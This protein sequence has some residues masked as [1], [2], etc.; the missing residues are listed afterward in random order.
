MDGNL[1]VQALLQEGIEALRRAALSASGITDHDGAPLDA[2]VLLA[3][4]LS[5]T[6]AQLKSHPEQVP[7]QDR[8]A[9]YR[10]LIQRRAAGEPTAYMI[11]H[12]EFWSLRLTVNT[13][14]LIPRPETELLVERALALHPDPSGTLLDLGTGSGAIALAIASE[15]P[16][17][18]ITATDISE[19]AL[20]TAQL[21]A[22]PLGFQNVEFLAG[23]WFAPLGGRRFNLVVANPPYIADSDPALETAPLRYEPRLA[24][25]A[26]DDGMACL[27][28]IIHSAPPYLERRGWLLLEHGSEQAPLVAR[29]LVVRGFSHVRS[30]RDLAGR[31]RM[32]EA[33]WP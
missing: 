26:A 23:D 14:V 27:H 28:R 1:T 13:T 29:A 21:N 5:T 17:W 31:E 30:L 22:A 18:R 32:T 25:A 8:A 20:T 2:E 24:L 12:R 15:R 7:N 4:A 16:A 10:I 9:R 3:H 19:T 33:Q 11:G 6:R